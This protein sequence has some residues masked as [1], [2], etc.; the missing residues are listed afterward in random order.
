[1][2]AGKLR[3]TQKIRDMNRQIK[4]EG[5][6]TSPA[7]PVSSPGEVHKSLSADDIFDIKTK[8]ADNPDLAFATWFQK[9]TGMP[10]EEL[11]RLARIGKSASDELAAEA[12]CKEF[13]NTHPEYALTDQNFKHLV[14]WLCK[15]EL[16]QPLSGRDPYAM[17]E[18]LH[19]AGKFTP[20]H[21]HKAYEDLVSDGFLELKSTEPEPEPEVAPV[22]TVKPAVAESATATPPTNGRIARE[23]RRPRAGLGIRTREA[24]AASQPGTEKPPSV[25]EFD[26]MSDEQLSK[27]YSDIRKSRAGTRR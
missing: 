21:L 9:K 18:V 27:I 4:L 17:I 10:V 20:D 2:S 19:N 23:E 6:Q 15:Y 26:N 24:I 1:L 16:G 13:T 8:L 11:V 3:A 7:A 22:E 5:G 12:V 14:S 25:E